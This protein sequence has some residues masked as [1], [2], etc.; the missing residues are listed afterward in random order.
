[1]VQLEPLL[2]PLPLILTAS[3]YLVMPCFAY[4]KSQPVLPGVYNG[5]VSWTSGMGEIEGWKTAHIVGKDLSE[6][7]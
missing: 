1:M 4:L 5:N 2:S 6:Q 3:L 7:K